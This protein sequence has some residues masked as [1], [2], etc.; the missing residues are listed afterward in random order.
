MPLRLQVTRLTTELESVQKQHR[1]TQSY[2]SAAQQ[3]AVR[4]ADEKKQV[5]RLTGRFCP[6][7]WRTPSPR[8]HRLVF[9]TLC[10][11]AAVEMV[12]LD[13]RAWTFVSQPQMEEHYTKS[14]ATIMCE[15]RFVES[16]NDE[17]TS[18]F[19]HALEQLQS[20]HQEQDE[21]QKQVGQCTASER[22]R[23]K[24]STSAS[25]SN[26]NYRNHSR[27]HHHQPLN[28]Q[29]CGASLAPNLYTRTRTLTSATPFQEAN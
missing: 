16:A 15:A 18:M 26:G 22:Y 27:C 5:S 14:A 21:L 1:D 12:C 11:N 29:S 23:C 20:A 28:V 7:Y 4:L 13:Q 3:L 2:L 6:R 19:R 17:L 8:V 10:F 25:G 24:S 9:S